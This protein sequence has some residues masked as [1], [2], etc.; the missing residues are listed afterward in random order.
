MTH[1]HP[2]SPMAGL[3]AAAERRVRTREVGLSIP[4]TNVVV[5][6]R[7]AD[8]KELARLSGPVQKAQQSGNTERTAKANVAFAKK[9][10]ASTCTGIYLRDDAGQLVS[11]D[12]DGD[13]PT[14]DARLCELLGK[15]VPEQ[16]SDIVGYLYT[17]VDVLLVS[18]HLQEFATGGEIEVIEALPGN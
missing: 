12:P 14:F 18:A 10:M 13:A 3:L 1:E 4:E 5:R 16:G 11:A 2:H 9:L 6:Y 17:D 7:A 8:Q 15:D